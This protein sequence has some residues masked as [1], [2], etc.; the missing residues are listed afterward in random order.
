MFKSYLKFS[1]NRK[2]THHDIFKAW[3]GITQ[4]SGKVDNENIKN[5]KN[6]LMTV[7]FHSHFNSDSLVV[8]A[9]K[10]YVNNESLV[11]FAFTKYDICYEH[12]CLYRWLQ[13][14]FLL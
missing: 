12:M 10:T 2:F 7:S 1:N 5:K 3:N 11:S 9:N 4:F 13:F 8:A 14:P 6:G